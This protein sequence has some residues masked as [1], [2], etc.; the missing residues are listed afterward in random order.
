MLR[1][2]RSRGMRPAID[3]VGAGF[4]SL[5]HIVLTSPDVIIDRTLVDRVSVDPVL[6]TLVGSLVQFGAA[7]GAQVVAE[8]IETAVD[9]AAARAL[10]V[11]Y[12]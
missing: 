2:L 11:H 9:A 12:G 1:P 3:D 6:S 8:G 5:R 4:S 10:G 7:C